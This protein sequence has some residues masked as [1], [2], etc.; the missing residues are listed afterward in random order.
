MDALTFGS[1]VVKSLAWPATALVALVLFRTPIASAIR[2]VKDAKFSRTG[3]DLDFDFRRGLADIE[4]N[5]PPGASLTRTE[6]VSA[7]D[8]VEAGLPASYVINASW[9]RLEQA[10]RKIAVDRH[11]GDGRGSF[12][13]AD[14]IAGRIPLP[15]ET[16]GLI[17][18]LR[19]LRNGALTETENLSRTDAA[20]YETA[21]AAVLAKLPGQ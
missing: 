1:D 15:P 9:N 14:L 4:A 11:I 10:L 16:V 13:N 7:S 21:V 3:V 12:K 19:R 20:R 5:L 17:R 8:D 2:R 6:A 18:E